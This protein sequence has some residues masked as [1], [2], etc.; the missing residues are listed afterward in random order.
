MRHQANDFEAALGSFLEVIRKNRY[1]DDDGA[2]KA[3]IAIFQLVGEDQRLTRTY[4]PILSTA[5]H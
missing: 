5:L 3:C 2:R 4:R 1:Y